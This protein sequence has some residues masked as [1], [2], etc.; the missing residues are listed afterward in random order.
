MGISSVFFRRNKL[1]VQAWGCFCVSF[2]QTWWF[3]S[4]RRRRLLLNKLQH[5]IS[6]TCNGGLLKKNLLK[7]SFTTKYHDLLKWSILLFA[8]RVHMTF[9][10]TAWKSEHFWERFFL[11]K[12]LRATL[13]WNT[14]N[15][16]RSK[17]LIRSSCIE[18]G[19]FRQH[20]L[21]ANIQQ[22]EAW[23]CWPGCCSFPATYSCQI[24]FFF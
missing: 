14:A 16:S 9:E 6:N 17:A 7:I 1:S 10:N 23:W 4:R 19:C 18:S 11:K 15:S 12:K 13:C 24:F 22:H 8:R 20:M 21:S 3:W 5:I 2:L